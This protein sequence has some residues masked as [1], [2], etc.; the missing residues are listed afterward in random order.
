MKHLAEILDVPQLEPEARVSPL[1]KR[2]PHGQPACH[3]DYIRHWELYPS[4]RTREQAEHECEAAWVEYR[5]ECGKRNRE[6]VGWPTPK[7][8]A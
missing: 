4:G 6:A 1:L 3:A 7:E 2:G 8:A 5:R